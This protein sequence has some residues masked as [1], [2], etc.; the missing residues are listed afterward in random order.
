MS[1]GSSIRN[2]AA[3]LLG[4]SAAVQIFQFLFGIVLARLL[5]PADF[6]ML[7]TVQIFTGIASFVAGAG[8]GQALIRWKEVNDHD[9]HAVFTFQLLV[10]LGIYATFF[11]TSRWFASYFGNPLYADLMRV[12]ALYFLLRPFGN[13]ANVWLTREMR[14]R[15]KIIIEFWGTLLTGALSI[16]MAWM[17]FKVWSL[18]FGGMIASVITIVWMLTVIPVRPRLRLDLAVVKRLGGYGFRTT[19]NDFVDYLRRQTA[20]F[21]LS[22]IGG[23]TVVGLYNKADSLARAPMLVA[24]SVYDPIFRSMSKVQ[25][26]KDQ[27]RYVYFRTIALLAVYMLPIVVGLAWI[28]EPLVLFLYG[29]KWVD[30]GKPLSILCLVGALACVRSPA[31]AVLAAQNWLGREVFVH[32]SNLLL[33]AV[34]AY[35]GLQWGLVG[36]AWGILAAQAFGTIY[37]TLLVKL[38]IGARY[39]QLVRSVAPGLVLNLTLVAA[40]VATDALLPAGLAASRPS[41]YLMIV[42]S[43]GIGTYLLAFLFAPISSL[44]SEQERWKRKAVLLL[45]RAG[46]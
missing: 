38:C 27:C 9:F 12:S 42:V 6:G 36:V 20:N 39:S 11:T 14:F 1:L 21:V 44:R 41:A 35:F 28:A 19:V 16:S 4:G 26:D 17:G 40:L 43:A 34:A 18:V 24:R 13:L 30:A 23:P 5:V 8:M 46:S 7:V 3:W 2:S 22:R 25:D 29:T 32:L 15:Q 10:G 37:M 45:S 33:I 31:G